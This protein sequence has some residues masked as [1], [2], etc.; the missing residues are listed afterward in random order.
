MSRLIIYGDV[1]GCYNELKKLR[2]KIDPKKNSIEV[3]VGDIITKG[4]DSIKV[5]DYLIK[6]NIKSVLGNHEDRLLQHLNHKKS[7]KKNPISLNKNEQDII[8]NLSSKHI[9]YLKKLPIYLKYKNIVILHG[10]I[11]N[12][13]NLKKLTKHNIKK[14]LTLKHLNKKSLFWADK[15]N[16]NQGF[17]VYGHQRLEK[18]K[19]GKYSLGIDTGCVNGNKLTAAIFKNPS[20][21]TYRIKSIKA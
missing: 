3:C 7:N 11:L 1:H 18:I 10:G 13:M 12:N 15:Y 8:D 4:E 16:G 19:K 5:L 20:V 14:I 9:K 2:K 6:H 17:I 21:K